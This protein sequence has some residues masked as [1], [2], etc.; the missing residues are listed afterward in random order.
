MDNSRGVYALAR[1]NLIILEQQN[2][3]KLFNG[4]ISAKVADVLAKSGIYA[5]ERL[6]FMSEKEISGIKGIG[7]AALKEVLSYRKLYLP[8]A[9]E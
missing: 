8:G 5:P 6:L 3:T 7:P 1:D 2:K 4:R 9:S